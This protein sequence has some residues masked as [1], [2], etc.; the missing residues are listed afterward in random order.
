MQSTADYVT[1]VNRTYRR[2]PPGGMKAVVPRVVA[3]NATP[4]DRI[5]DYGAGKTATAAREL[6]ERGLSVIAHDIGGN[7][8][9]RYHEP[10][11]LRQQYDIVYASNV[12]NVQ[13]DEFRLAMVL[14][15]VAGV[16]VPGGMFIA[17]YPEPR[18]TAVPIDEIG[19]ILR[20]RF[21]SAE[22]VKNVG[23]PTWV[24]RK[25]VFGHPV[26]PASVPAFRRSRAVRRR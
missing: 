20:Q 6:R 10:A 17:N 15:E 5:L 21:G 4:R 25:D 8:D 12:L 1:G 9:H 19:E 26:A 22:R 2:T 13:P 16:L 24:C 23:S 11:A 14:D 7:F 18:K 3:E